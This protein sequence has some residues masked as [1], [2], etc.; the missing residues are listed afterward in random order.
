[1]SYYGLVTTLHNFHKDPNSDRLYLA[2]CFGE[3]VIVGPD[4][5]EGMPVLYLPADGQIERWFGD[6]FKLSRK[7][8]DGTAQGG[9]IEN[10]KIIIL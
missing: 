6:K 9:Y 10:N 2:D 5:Y 3:G 4:C 1:M 8:L 7:N